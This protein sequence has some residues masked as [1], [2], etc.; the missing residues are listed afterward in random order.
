MTELIP[1]LQDKIVDAGGFR[2]IKS[3]FVNTMYDESQNDFFNRLHEQ[4]SKRFES[5][6]QSGKVDLALG[7]VE[8]PFRL[9]ALLGLQDRPDV[10]LDDQAFH[11]LVFH[12]YRQVESTFDDKD[13]WLNLMEGAKGDQASFLSPKDLAAFDALPESF[14]IYRGAVEMENEKGISYSINANTA[15]WFAERLAE[16]GSIVLEGTVNKKDI[17]SYSNDR[18]E[19]EVIVDPDLVK[20][21][22][23]YELELGHSPEMGIT[24]KLV[25]QT[26][27][28]ARDSVSDL[29]PKRA[30]SKANK[31]TI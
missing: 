29:E 21:G 27:E 14:T 13:V 5:L 7:L 2:L 22:R 8:K 31:M 4:N 3:A 19:M 15:V 30:V 23:T 9:I 20:F 12:A 1:E 6:I 11:N 25:I 18:G 28:T 16:S 26:T 10:G 24:E 17:L